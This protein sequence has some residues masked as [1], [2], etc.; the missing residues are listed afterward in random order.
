MK[1][2]EVIGQKENVLTEALKYE[3][4]NDFLK[5]SKGSHQSAC[6]NG[7]IEEAC[8]HMEPLRDPTSKIG[9]RYGYIIITGVISRIRPTN[10]KK[11]NNFEYLCD[12]GNTGSFQTTNLKRRSKQKLKASCGCNSNGYR[13][14]LLLNQSGLNTCFDCKQSLPISEFGNN[15]SN[16]NGLQRS[17]KTCKSERDKKYREDPRFRQR[18]LNQK[19]E[20]FYKIKKDPEKWGEYLKKQ[21]ETRDYRSE[22]LRMRNNPIRRSKDAIRKLIITS[23]KVRNITKSKIRM[24]TEEIIGCDLISFKQ[25]IESQF[26][27]GMTWLN[28]GKWHLDHIIPMDAAKTVDEV[29]KLNHWT[30]F[31]PLWSDDNYN[32][33]YYVLDEHHDLFYKLLGREFDEN[34]NKSQKS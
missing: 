14:T 25:H 17:C 34:N 3:T 15:K 20:D 22:Y 31:Q 30:N 24:N 28:H 7:W 11:I 9:K 32:K 2:K 4:K 12:C 33:Y 27:E 13:D 8:S 16:K 21:K 26:T 19:K 18:I 5:N 10:N 1:K 23:L 6:K 29:I